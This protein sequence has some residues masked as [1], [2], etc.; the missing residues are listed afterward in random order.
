MLS[1]SSAF[2]WLRAA[3]A[4]GA[5]CKR[6]VAGRSGCCKTSSD[7][8][9]IFPAVKTKNPPTGSSGGGWPKSWL[10]RLFRFLGYPPAR[11]THV[12]IAVQQ[13]AQTHTTFADRVLVFTANRLHKPPVNHKAR[14]PQRF[15]CM[16]VSGKSA[17]HKLM[18]PDL[19]RVGFVRIHMNHPTEN[20]REPA[21]AGLLAR[22]LGCDR[23]AQSE[24]LKIR[25]LQGSAPRRKT[26]ISMFVPARHA[27][28]HARVQMVFRCQFARSVHRAYQ[29]VAIICFLIEQRRRMRRVELKAR[30]ECVG[31]VREVILRLWNVGP[32]NL[33]SVG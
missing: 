10:L 19:R 32:E 1:A 23:T 28:R 9:V 16:R 17:S 13:H 29:L 2:R 14:L 24:F 5:P 11:Q 26:K 30:F 25:V 15:A 18:R 12:C 7:A 4:A 6:G 3:G 27:Q 8:K 21:S 20:L 31:V 33:E 22:F